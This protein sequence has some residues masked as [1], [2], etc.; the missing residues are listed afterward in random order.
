MPI[1]PMI[2]MHAPT[3]EEFATKVEAASIGDLIRVSITIV[4]IHDKE[5]RSHDFF[6][7]FVKAEDSTVDAMWVAWEA[8]KMEC[9]SAVGQP[10]KTP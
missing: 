10:Q 3:Y 8:K 6:Q 5:N 1:K 4:T 9:F 7:T 2:E